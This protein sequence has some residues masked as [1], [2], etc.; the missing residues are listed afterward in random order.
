MA[1][2][3]E[4]SESSTTLPRIDDELVVPAV[5][6]ADPFTGSNPLDLSLIHI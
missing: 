4:I 5:P 3:G 2:P 6:P 1:A